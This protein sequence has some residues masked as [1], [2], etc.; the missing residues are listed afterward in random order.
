MCV[1]VRVCEML[2]GESDLSGQCCR[3]WIRDF[4]VFI[5]LVGVF[6]SSWIG[7]S[8]L[9]LGEWFIKR[10]SLMKHTYS[11]SKLLSLRVL[12]VL[13]FLVSPTLC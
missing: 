11:A 5:F 7:A 4:I 12:K 2:G 6:E 10:I 13:R 8:L 1:S 3:A 9:R